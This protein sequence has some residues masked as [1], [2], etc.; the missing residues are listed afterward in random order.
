MLTRPLKDIDRPLAG[1]DDPD[2]KNAATSG[3]GDIVIAILIGIFCFAAYNANMRAIPAGDTYGARYMPFSILR[4]HSVVLDPILDIIA[5][6]RIPPALGEDT[7]AFWIT[8]ARGPHYVSTY[9]IALPI[10]I[11]PLYIPAVTYLDA[12]GWD[13]HLVDQVARVMEKLVASLIAVASVAL[14]YL[15][16]R[17]RAPSGTA[18][19]LSLVYAFG[20]T[21]WVISSQALWAHG[22][23]Q[24][25]VVATM[26]LLTGPRIESPARLRVVMAGFL[27]ALIAANRPPDAILATALGLYGLRW[28]GP[29]RLL[30]VAAGLVPV[31]LTVAYNLM[32]V[33]H[34][35]GAYALFVRPHDY[36]D[37][38]LGGIAGLLVSPTRGLFV[39]SPFLLF[40]PFLFPLAMRGRAMRDLTLLM[41]GAIVLQIVLYA[42][43]DWRQGMAW[44]PR[45]LGDGL[46]MLIWML[47]PIVA[48]LSRPGCMLFGMA[49]G[50]AILI[51][52]VGAFWYVGAADAGMGLGE[53]GPDRMRPMWRPENAPFVA[54]LRHPPAAFDLL[55]RLQGNIDQIEVVAEE[56]GGAERLIDAAGWAL[57]DSRSPTD[58][59]ILVDGRSVA[60]TGTFFTR[61]DVVQTLGETSPAGWRMRFPV[62]AL[63]PGRHELAVL[64]RA[65]PGGEPRL[66]RQLSFDLP[67]DSPAWRQD[68]QFQRSADL[69]RQRLAEHQRPEGYWLTAFTGVPRFEAPQDEM[70]TYLNA[71]ML[72]IAGPAATGTPLADVL[73]RTRRFLAE[74]IEADGLVRY[75]GRPDTPTIG[76]LG[77]AIT[78]DSDDTALVWRVAP[79]ASGRDRLAAA[80]ETIGRFRREDGL[81]RTWLAE[82]AQYRCLDPG[83][84]PNPADIGIQMHIL[85]LLAQENPPAARAL[86]EALTTRTADDDL[87]V[88]YAD[89][90]PIVILRLAELQQAGCPLH[91]PP[92]RLRTDVPGQEIWVQAAEALSRIR[93]GAGS[94]LETNRLLE[95]LATED[96]AAVSRMP[97][98]LYHND[99]T[100]S[101]RRFYWSEDIGYALW[102]RLY[103]ERQ[104]I[105]WAAQDCGEEGR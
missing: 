23:A 84:D 81:Y 49:C 62:G 94:C 100:A 82:R 104:R 67:A 92:S 78:P 7:S 98:L 90:P 41:A 48:A 44:G 77:C 43:V 17:R 103:Y 59:M 36:N 15:L 38:I 11:A 53:R 93:T 19:L 101:V 50:V 51:Q 70:N 6:G 45:W 85:L 61:P 76:T 69:A 68:Q 79:G 87:W 1:H 56:S 24:L 75:H 42:M 28:A 86:C 52:A 27:C 63:A 83:R 14:L 35:A 57:V 37:D 29:R 55:R 80:L 22:P 16:L 13:P 91:P 105:G 30:F 73:A 102:L 58:A 96:F 97:P 54:E 34:I 32:V 20:T 3:F 9:P 72:D 39:F 18:T 71:V 46:P 21:T 31:A 8:H 60:G 65:D 99:L 4:N 12:R 95:R 64:V 25:L 66:L 47:P 5:Q 88:Y 89:A 2:G 74:Q 40:I 26:L 10:V 33:G